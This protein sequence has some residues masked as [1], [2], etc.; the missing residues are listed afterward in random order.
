M[1]RIAT[2]KRRENPDLHIPDPKTKND[3]LQ[4]VDDALEYGHNCCSKRGRMKKRA[5]PEMSLPE[6]DYGFQRKMAFPPQFM[7]PIVNYAPLPEIQ[8]SMPIFNGVNPILNPINNEQMN[9]ARILFSS[10]VE[11]N[12]IYRQNL[13]SQMM[14]KLREVATLQ[15][16]IINSIAEINGQKESKV[17][18]PNENPIPNSFLSPQ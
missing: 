4:Y 8:Y 16:N 15:Q 10:P 6:Y 14:E 9:L 18:K 3:L 13:A 12:E 2:K 1:R 11:N 17:S 5:E 7:F